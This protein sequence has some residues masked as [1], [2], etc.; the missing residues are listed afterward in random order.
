M[1]A[2]FKSLGK[3]NMQPM[4]NIALRAARSA[5]EMIVKS[6]DNL[7][8]VKVDEKGRH[9]LLPLSSARFSVRRRHYGAADLPDGRR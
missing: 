6:A 4:V 7:D 5:G 8:L 2:L 9:R 3:S 1:R